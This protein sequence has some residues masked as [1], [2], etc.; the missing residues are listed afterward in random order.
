MSNPPA[1]PEFGCLGAMREDA[2]LLDQVVAEAMRIRQL[3]ARRPSDEDFAAL[4]AIAAATNRTVPDVL[5]EAILLLRLH[6]NA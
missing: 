4:E 6:S 2:D 1:A 5:N 3:Q